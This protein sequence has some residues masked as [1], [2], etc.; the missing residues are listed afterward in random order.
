MKKRIAIRHFR[1]SHNAPYLPPKVLHNLC[2]LFL[3]LGI[4]A[5]KLKTMLMQN[6]GGKCASGV[7]LFLKV[8][9]PSSFST[10]MVLVVCVDGYDICL[11]KSCD[12][13]N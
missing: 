8:M 6:L 4:T 2:F 5:Q 9:S 11:I 12:F 1:I 10:F 7:L 3:L 13:A